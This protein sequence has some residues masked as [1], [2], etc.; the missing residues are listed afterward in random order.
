LDGTSG[1]VQSSDK[2]GVVLETT[3]AATKQTGAQTIGGTDMT[4]AWA[5]SRSVGG[6]NENN[7]VTCQLGFVGNHKLELP[8]RPGVELRPLFGTH[9]LTAFSD[10]VK[11]FQH[12]DAVWWET[13]NKAAANGMQISAC[14]TA[15]LIAQPFPSAFGSRAFALQDASSGTE[16]FAPLDRLCARNLNTVRGDKQ[17]NLAEVNTDNILWRVAWFGFRN[18]NGDMQVEF[19]VP[20]TFENCGSRVGR[21]K[22][23]QIALPDFDGALHPLAVASSDANPNFVVFQ[24]QSEKL[25]V[26]IQGLG[27]ENQ[28]F[29]RLLVGFE[30]FVCFCNTV[31]GTDSKISME[32]EPLSDVSVGQMVESNG[33]EASSLKCYLAD[34][35]TGG[36]EDI[37]RSAQPLFVLWRQ[38]KFDDNGQFHPLNYT[39]HTGICQGGE[40]RYS[41]VS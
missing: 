27:F 11:V 12:N 30:G 23:W 22:D 36:C 5:G 9:T 29:Q 26:Q 33:I 31:K 41:S 25:C 4:T 24:E 16:S 14:P 17:V 19:S 39:A 32:V 6:S 20:V 21:S 40:W 8:K 10:A 15:F 13:I 28:K 3:L 34:G 38:V 18:G 1:D 7:L 35:I 37:Q 2:I